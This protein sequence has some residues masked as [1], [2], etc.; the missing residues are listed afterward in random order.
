MTSEPRRWRITQHAPFGLVVEPVDPP[1]GETAVIDVVF[2]PDD[3][4]GRG[5]D[6]F[7]PVG[8]IVEARVQGRTPSGQ[9]R[10]TM[11]PNDL[12]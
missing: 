2:M 8:A 1:G 10:L 4:R 11:L 6:D 7:P 9:L 5:Q 12:D 3:V